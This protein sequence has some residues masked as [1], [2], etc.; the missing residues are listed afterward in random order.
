MNCTV[1]Y[2]TNVKIFSLFSVNPDSGYVLKR[3]NDLDSIEETHCIDFG[4]LTENEANLTSNRPTAHQ[5]APSLKMRLKRPK[6]PIKLMMIV[7]LP[8]GRHGSTEDPEFNCN[9]EKLSLMYKVTA[10]ERTESFLTLASAE[11]F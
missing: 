2:S 3:K 9:Y 5:T 1:Q 11:A 4:H 7:T 8:L 10:L 6:P